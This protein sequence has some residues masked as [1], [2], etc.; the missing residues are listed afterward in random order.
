MQTRTFDGAHYTQH[1]SGVF[2]S[3]CG[4]VLDGATNTYVRIRTCKNPDSYLSFSYLGR[5]YD[6]H[7]VVAEVYVPKPTENIAW[8]VNH[9]DGN[10][11]N[12]HADNLEWVT[13][14]RNLTHAYESGLRKDSQRVVVVDLVTDETLTFGSIGQTAKYFDVNPG[15]IHSRLKWQNIAK[16]WKRR[17]LIVRDGEPIPKVDKST[18]TVIRNGE[19]KMVL[20]SR[21]GRN[22]VF[23]FES[24]SAAAEHIGRSVALLSKR[25]KQALIEGKPGVDFGEWTFSLVDREAAKVLADFNIASNV[26]SN[27]FPKRTA[28]KVKVT[29]LHTGEEE[30]LTSLQE[31]ADKLN[32]SKSSLQKQVHKYGGVWNKRLKVEYLAL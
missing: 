1:P 21:L 24:M 10:K 16:V 11:R 7:R 6:T 8:I 30:I 18:L 28:P 17:Y 20:G 15:T 22:G 25:F 12:N 27:S 23:L 31:L 13:Y 2:V 26:R 32:V 4:K 9:K 14:S 19:S 29:D 3:K 5:K